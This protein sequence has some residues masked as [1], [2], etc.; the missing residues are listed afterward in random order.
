MFEILSEAFSFVR[1][2]IEAICF[3]KLAYSEI[4]VMLLK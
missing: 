1:I 3:L 4:K 2:K